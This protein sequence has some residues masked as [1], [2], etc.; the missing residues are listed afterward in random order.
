M[1]TKQNISYFSSSVQQAKRKKKMNAHEQ[2]QVFQK[3]S[4]GHYIYYE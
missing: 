3:N 4:K 2:K 1:Q